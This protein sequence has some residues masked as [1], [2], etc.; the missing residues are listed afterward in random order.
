MSKNRNKLVPGSK[1][2]IISNDFQLHGFN[3]GEIVE[4]VNPSMNT[5]K[6][7]EGSYKM[8][9][10]LMDHEFRILKDGK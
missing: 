1:V 4:A 9:Q 5:F 3:V 7:I 8:E 6:R 10:C 2:E